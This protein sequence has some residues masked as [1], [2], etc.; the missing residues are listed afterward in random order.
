M[1]CNGRKS[2]DLLQKI[3]IQLPGKPSFVDGC[4]SGTIMYKYIIILLLITVA[5]AGCKTSTGLFGKKT[6]HEQYADKLGSAGLQQTAAG[7]QW[8]DAATK[9]INQPLNV[10]LPYRETGYFDAAN[11]AAAGYTFNAR[12][13]EKLAIRVTK[14]PLAG[15]ALFLDLWQPVNG[16][17]PR[18]LI[19]ADSLAPF[20]YEVMTDGTYI[21]RLQPELLAG[22]EYTLTIGIGP[23][24][25][26][27][28]PAAAK[29]RLVSVWGNPRDG[30]ARKHEGIDIAAAKRTPL[31]ACANGT[32][33]SV[34]EENLGGKVIFLRPDGRDYS[35]YY[36]HLDEQLV[37]AGQH[38]QTGDTIGLVG[39]TGNAKT[40]GP[41]LHFGIYTNN[42]AI[43][44]LPFV[45][46]NKPE[47]GAISALLTLLYQYVRS[48]KNTMVSA[49]PDKKAAKLV[50]LQNN[51]IIRVIAATA[52][53]Y[54]VQLP[55][56][57][58][59]FVPATAVSSTE[60]AFT[61][62]L[63]ASRKN[64]FGQPDTAAAS[65]IIIEKGSKLEVLGIWN[66]FYFVKHSNI[67]GWVIP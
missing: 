37:Y 63:A 16:G 23:S 31:L 51:S 11:P 52:S 21:L 18:F 61:N 41:H 6:L 32:I 10:T 22:G 20:D 9:A 40:T 44:P 42:G 30:G 45:D 67:T 3:Q 5:V 35:L 17:S 46:K 25:A 27:P 4:F 7:R 24:L 34:K 60:K 19:A 48:G 8:F 38:V 62:Y 47:P 29:P 50:S 43:D 54:K 39:N 49:S 56:G 1:R 14:K 53:W 66:R 28:I 12:R 13:G 33:T 57:I 2:I 65:K 59:G 26:Y 58:T 55:D 15:F 36:A 64:L